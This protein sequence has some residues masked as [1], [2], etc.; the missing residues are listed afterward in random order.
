MDNKYLE[1]IAG[2]IP[3]VG[4]YLGHLTGKTMRDASNKVNTLEHLMA[5]A[6]EGGTT[7]EQL[8][9]HLRKE[10]EDAK[11]SRNNTLIGTGAAVGTGVAGAT[12]GYK[13]Y[14]DKKQKE[15]NALEDSI[16]TK[17]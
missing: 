14:V 2:W 4:K 13:K 3:D 7:V 10:L 12:Y 9:P 5:R 8:L 11:R 1:K 6:K 16:W 17:N 15:I